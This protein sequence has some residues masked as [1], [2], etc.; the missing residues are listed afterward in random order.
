MASQGNLYQTLVMA[1]KEHLDRTGRLPDSV[2]ALA[3]LAKVDL[4]DAQQIFASPQ[5]I[6][7][8]LI[9]QGVI[10]LND[11]LREGVLET[12]SQDP[13]SQ[14][15]ALAEGYG[16]WAERNPALFRLLSEGLNQPM[17]EDGTLHRYTLSMRELFLRK[18]TE[19]RDLASGQG[20]G[21]EDLLLVLHALVKGANTLFT[22][23]SFDP[24]L[25]GDSRSSRLL[26]RIVF[27][28][29]ING[30][31]RSHAPVSEHAD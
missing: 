1:A 5:A 30:I 4:K 21:P 24:W 28:E 15:R 26:T 6:Y 3:S 19:M 16:E 14:L 8:G 12:D 13:V 11:A 2:A 17:A 29:F 23:R 9:Y 31:L 10:L 25:H 27:D 22:T 18:L 20:H 7:D